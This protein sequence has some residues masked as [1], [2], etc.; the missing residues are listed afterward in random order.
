MSIK[1][2]TFDLDNTLWEVDPVIIE[3]EKKMRGW[4]AE[5]VPTYH[6]QIDRDA[7]TA[8]RK[9][10]VEAEPGIVTDLSEMRIRVMDLAIQQLGHTTAAARALAEGAFGVFFE[11]RHDVE[12][13]PHALPMLAR[14]AG[15]YTIGALTNGNADISLVPAL[16]D[17]MAFQFSSASERARKPEP[18]MFERAI[19]HTGADPSSV[20]HVGDNPVDDIQGANAVG[21]RTVWVNLTNADRGTLPVQPDAEVTRLDELPR[22]IDAL[23]G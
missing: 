15:R 9:R 6:E 7:M 22:A 8:I 10:V 21:M 17:L 19:A 2:I 14:L 3:A 16:R 12:F 1:V 11:A 20:V 18:A 4:L 23:L 13:Y 5:H